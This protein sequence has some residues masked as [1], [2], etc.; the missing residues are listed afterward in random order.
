MKTLD[1]VMQKIAYEMLNKHA[2]KVLEAVKADIKRGRTPKQIEKSL[3]AKKFQNSLIAN[4]AVLAA[5]HI[6]ENPDLQ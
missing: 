4:S 2:P 1:K 3:S 5:Y 6:K